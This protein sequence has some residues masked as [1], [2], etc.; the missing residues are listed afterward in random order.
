[1]CVII[2]I[3]ICVMIVLIINIA[4]ITMM[5]VIHNTNSITISMINSLGVDNIIT[6][7][8]IVSIPTILSVGCPPAVWSRSARWSTGELASLVCLITTTPDRNRVCM[9]ID[10][11]Q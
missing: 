7:T 11:Q 6:I 9:N 8:L 4:S 5:T 2:G 1:M 10:V 3:T